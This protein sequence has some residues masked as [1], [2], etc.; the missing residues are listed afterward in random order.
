MV[1]DKGTSHGL[2]WHLK[3]HGHGG[4]GVDN[5]PHA[6]VELDVVENQKWH[7]VERKIKG[8]GVSMQRNTINMNGNELPK[9]NLRMRE[10]N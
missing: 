10:G 5:R 2:D 7:H 3:V 6:S 8:N 1:M 4:V 9:G